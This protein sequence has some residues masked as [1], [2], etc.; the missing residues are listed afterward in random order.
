MKSIS[1]MKV[2]RK[3]FPELK[4]VRTKEKSHVYYHIINAAIGNEIIVDLRLKRVE[5]AGFDTLV[6]SRDIVVI[7]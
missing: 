2:L 3:M 6:T 5:N 1:P 4:I 7:P